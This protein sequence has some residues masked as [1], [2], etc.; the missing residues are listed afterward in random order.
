MKAL[1]FFLF[2]QGSFVAAS[3][4]EERA[5]FQENGYLWIKDFFTPEQVLD[6]RNWAD[7]MNRAA[8]A[9]MA[10]KQVTP[11]PLILVPERSNQLQV[12]RVEDMMTCYP[13][14]HKFIEANVTSF[15]QQL[16]GTPYILF[17][18]KLN[19]KWPGGGAF[20][21][22]QDFPAYEAFAP[23]IHVTAMICIDAATLQNGCLQVAKN[24]SEIAQAASVLPYI[25]GG[26]A[27]GSIQ[28]EYVKK[29]S[30]LP[31][32]TS[33]RDLVLINSF[34][35]HYS[36]PNQSNNPRR[37]MFFTY[38][39]LEE[40]EFRTAYYNTK[41]NDPDNPVFHFGTPTNARGK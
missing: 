38:N 28:P 10:S 15:L 9:Q 5:F 24:W 39:K 32:I 31:L 13:A 17:K 2:L 23:R 12:C 19:F 6:L 4:A 3:L 30:W 14:F 16:L 20:L 34:V 1:L 29:L 7:E 11:I 37:A 21:P 41:R 33:P 18:D 22:H 25:E 26:S 35:P 36:E 40:G 27:H 8:E